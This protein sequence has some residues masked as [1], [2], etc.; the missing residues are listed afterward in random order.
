[1][2]TTTTERLAVAAAA[3]LHLGGKP[4]SWI[5]GLDERLGCDRHG[6]VTLA[7][8]TGESEILDD[9]TALAAALELSAEQFAQE[10]AAEVALLTITPAPHWATRTTPWN[11]GPVE[12][13]REHMRDLDTAVARDPFGRVESWQ[14]YVVEELT[15]GKS[16]LDGLSLQDAEGELVF[17]TPGD[18]RAY[19]KAL[20]EAADEFEKIVGLT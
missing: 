11:G 10:V 15:G 13:S 5:N 14:I 8:I 17:P 1:M 3:A 19:A 7:L 20:L 4:I 12:R 18:A 2:S 6:D 9:Q 16:T